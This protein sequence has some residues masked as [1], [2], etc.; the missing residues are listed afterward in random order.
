MV[1]EQPPAPRGPARSTGSTRP[2][3]L[4]GRGQTTDGWATRVLEM[5][6]TDF[7][8]Y[9]WGNTV[10][11]IT[12]GLIDRP[13]VA[14]ELIPYGTP[15][16]ADLLN[17][18]DGRL[19]EGTL[20]PV[21]IAPMARF[22]GVGDIVLRDDLQYERYNLARPRQTW[23]LF[24]AAPGVRPVATFGGTAENV[25]D[26]SL[27]LQDELELAAPPD[28]PDPAQ[29][30]VLE[31]ED[32][33]GIFRAIPATAPV[34]LAGDGDGLVDLGVRRA[35]RRHRGGPVLGLVRR[36]RAR[37]WTAS[38]IAPARSSCSPT[39]TAGPA[40]AGARC[41]RTT[42]TPSRPAR[43][44]SATTRPTT[45]CRSSPTPV[46][47]RPPWPSTGAACT[48]GPPPTATRS[49]SP[50]ED[51]AANAV[52][53]DRRTAWQV[54]AFSPVAGRADRAHLR[55]AP[56]HRPHHGPAG[57]QR[58]AEPLDHPGAAALRRRR[59]G[60]RR[61]RR[62]VPE[63]ARPE[64]TLR[65]AHLPHAS[66]S[67]CSTTT[68]ARRDRYDGLS[69]VGFADIRLGDGDR[70]LDEVIRLPRDL[71]DRGRRRLGRPAPR[72]R[73]HPPAHPAEHPA[74]QRP[75]AG[76]GPGVRAAHRPRLRRL[77]PG[78]HLA[79]RARR[80]DRPRAGRHRRRRVGAGR[81]QLPAP[82]G[83]HR[84]PGGERHRRRPDHALEPRPTST[85]APTASAT[86]SSSRS[87][88]TTSTSGWSPTAATPCPPASASRPTARPRRPST[89]PAVPDL[90]AKDATAVVPLDF[91]TVTGRDLRFVIDGVRTVKTDRLG[92]EGTRSPP[93]SASPSS[94]RPG[95]GPP[96]RPGPS[97]AGA[98]TTS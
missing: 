55:P 36:R 64:L 9:R 24:R 28:L 75:R 39:P 34:L 67:R 6:G 21:A 84:G 40:G 26:P 38:S 74:A 53:D 31:V 59:P 93:R 3:Y 69:A 5:P 50:P 30:A 10:D 56:H 1:A 49:P 41:G 25:P 32:P 92:L 91:P 11:P 87:R 45:A 81:H 47:T 2:Q 29:V 44:R 96:C 95:S 8:S 35:G 14:R 43:S 42:A 15:P 18:F 20:D 94:A 89:C 33:V 70:R 76:P 78:P 71:L 57:R 46:T 58:R 63:R 4:D 13:Y 7:A 68:S 37:A 23:A 54:G 85:R 90:E 48:P 77:G 12:P 27:P 17:A 79:A 72:H 88:S 22:M 98:G 19:Q 86:G 52:D 60:R 83:R 62:R 51:R 61:P 80:G 66:R 97:T 82:A 65:P 73:A 16:S